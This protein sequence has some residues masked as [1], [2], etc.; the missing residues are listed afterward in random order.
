[1]DSKN[2]NQP[3]T[4]KANLNKK[5]KPSNDERCLE[6]ESTEEPLPPDPKT[7]T[8]LEEPGDE[9]LAN[10]MTA[11]EYLQRKDVIML[12]YEKQIFLD[13]V[14]TDGLT[15]CAKWVIKD[16][17]YLII[18][19]IYIDDIYRNI[20]SLILQRFALR[21]RCYKYLEGLQ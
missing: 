10:V 7:S 4:S 12:E 2:D 16:C 19:V 17:I 20:Y 18:Y 3:S 14:A 6:E 21:S 13:I 9:T 8:I 15:V 11:E 5:V 1:M